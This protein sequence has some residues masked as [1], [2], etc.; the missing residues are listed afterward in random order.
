VSVL[1]ELERVGK[2]FGVRVAVE[3]VSLSLR[4]GEVF[5]LLGPNGAGKT[6]LLRIAVNLLVPDAGAV[7]L[8]GASPG[9]ALLEQI[10]Y[11]PEE[12]GLP[13]RPRAVE[14]LAYFG[15]LKGLSRAD[16]R[17]QARRLLGRVQLEARASS[18]IGELSKGNQQKLQIAAA[19]MGRPRLLLVDEPFSGLDPVNRALA[20][21]LLR[22]GVAEGAAVLVST[23]QLQE[24]QQLCDRLLLLHRGRVLL[25]GPVDEVRAR[26]ADGSL[27]VRGDAN[28]AQLP[29]VASVVRENGG[30]QRLLLRAGATS[31]EVLRQIV[32]RGLP[33][34]SFETHLPSVEQIFVRLVTEE[35]TG[36]AVEALHG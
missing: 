20:L 9:P 21:E 3:D 17:A 15:E 19:L 27:L 26:F 7:R 1:L 2:R 34:A 36:P 24:V 8:F 11:L 13:E 33:V 29:A 5:G 22:E 12:R 16:A 23:H 31:G 30:R 25:Q 18:R 35:E 32:E 4:A 28:Y 10:G 6:T 14:M